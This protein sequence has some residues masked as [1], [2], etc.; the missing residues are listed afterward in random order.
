MADPTDARTGTYN[1][2]RRPEGIPARWLPA[3]VKKSHVRETPMINFKSRRLSGVYSRFPTALLFFSP[4][5]D[6]S[7]HH[8]R[9]RTMRGTA[10]APLATGRVRGNERWVLWGG[11]IVCPSAISALLVPSRP[12]ACPACTFR[13]SWRC[14][15]EPLWQIMRFW[16]CACVQGLSP[17]DKHC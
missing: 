4:S 9:V 5:A 17:H 3:T 8:S 10:T 16:C 11:N 1:P 2:S 6:V 15:N 13:R 14:D 7:P 12:P